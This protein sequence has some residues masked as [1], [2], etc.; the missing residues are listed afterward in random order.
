MGATGTVLT[1][2]VLPAT[3][4]L[5]QIDASALRAA[6]AKKSLHQLHAV[7]STVG[8]FL[9]HWQALVS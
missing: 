2:I 5:H 8:Q 3:I 1:T 7:L 9:Q 6:F 4:S